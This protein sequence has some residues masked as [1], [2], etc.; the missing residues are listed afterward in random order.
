MLR[1]ILLW[2]IGIPVIV[3][4]LGVVV[5][6]VTASLRER[7]DRA[8]L[9]PQGGQFVAAYDTRVFVQRQGDPSAPAVVFIAGTGGWSGLWHASMSQAVAAGF[10]AIAID[11]PPFGYAYPPASGNY[12]K[13]EQGRRLLAALDSLGVRKAVFVAHSIGAAPTMEA[14]F[15]DPGRTRALVLV[16]PALGVDTAQT[17]GSDSGVQAALRHAWIARP[18][19]ALLTNPRFTTSLLQRVITEKDKATPELVAIYQRPLGLKGTSA[20]FAKWLPEVLAGRGH[21]SSDDL[22]SYGKL[23]FPVTLIWG[24][25]DTVTP[26]SQGQHLQKLIPG[27]TLITIPRAGHGPQF[28]EPALFS[29]ALAAAL[30]K[31]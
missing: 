9:H 12:S 31:S 5:I 13:K 30:T 22:L 6:L 20:S 24:E 14:V 27:A 3:V 25:T 23:D 28:E 19:T 2:L 11:L 26:P 7:G 17:D 21:Q 1:R 15:A 18:V 10:Q 4:A 16:D 29:A 8:T